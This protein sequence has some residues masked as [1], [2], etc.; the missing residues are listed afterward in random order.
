[1]INL[2]YLIFPYS[3]GVNEI[4]NVVP[5]L[6]YDSKLPSLGITVNS[7]SESGV[8]AAVNGV[9]LLDLFVSLKVTL[10]VLCSAEL[11][12]I[13][14]SSFGSVASNVM[15]NLKERKKTNKI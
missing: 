4:I 12:Q 5:S 7:A 9:K 6:P 10:V 11:T 8:N 15:R 14:S 13:I 2:P 3:M 1:M